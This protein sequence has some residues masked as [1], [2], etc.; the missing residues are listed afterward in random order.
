MILLPV[1]LLAGASI[2]G[3]LLMRHAPA[4]G[5]DGYYYVLQVE[6][7]RDSGHLLPLPISIISAVP[8]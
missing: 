4:A 5:L 3:A 7:L 1:V 8:T 2:D 6:S